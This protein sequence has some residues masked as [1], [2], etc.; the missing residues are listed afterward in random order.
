MKQTKRQKK[1]GEIAVEK[2]YATPEDVNT[3]LAY[4]H[5]L[6]KKGEHELIGII[7]LKHDMLTNEQLIDIL[8]YY[9]TDHRE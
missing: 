1:F 6:K 4:Q 2:G 9:D 3:A 7:M 5:S 8:Q